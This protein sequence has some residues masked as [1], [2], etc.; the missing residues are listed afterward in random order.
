[1]KKILPLSQAFLFIMILLLAGCASMPSFRF[2][3]LTPLDQ[4]ET[5]PVSPEAAIPVSIRIAPVEIPDYL[6]RPQIVTWNGKN[7][8]QLAELDRWAGALKENIAVVLA[9]NLTLLLGSDRIFAYP[10]V[11]AE[12]TDYLLALRILRLDCTPGDRV[13]LKT[14]WT[15]YAGQDITGTTHMATFVEPLNDSRYETLVAA[16][17]HALGK[18]SREIA[19]KLP[20]KVT[21]Q[22]P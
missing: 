20:A 5:K 7:E 3:A 15:I 6:D 19:Q 4:Q 16:V 10:R 11:R 1:M 13:L 22:T 17:S 9:E 14:Q 8:L 18:V 12:K 21:P 2:Y